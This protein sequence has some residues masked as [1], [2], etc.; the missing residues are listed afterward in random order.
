[1]LNTLEMCQQEMVIVQGKSR[2]A[3]AKKEFNRKV[4]I[5]TN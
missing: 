2:I 1:M 3:I 5:L 4:S